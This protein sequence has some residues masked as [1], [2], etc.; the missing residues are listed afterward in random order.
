MMQTFYSF[1]DWPVEWV[2]LS[3]LVAGVVVAVIALLEGDAQ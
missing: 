3:A 2:V 1:E